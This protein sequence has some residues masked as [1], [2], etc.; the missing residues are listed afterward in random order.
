MPVQACS[1]YVAQLIIMDKCLNYALERKS[2]VYIST[3]KSYITTHI[4]CTSI[5][6]LYKLMIFSA[7]WM[8]FCWLLEGKKEKSVIFT[9]LL[10]E[11]LKKLFDDHAANTVQFYTILCVP[12]LVH[13][14]S[15][16]LSEVR[17]G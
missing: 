1:L 10:N 12:V 6:I 7:V 13:H 15:Y 4:S 9:P 14:F 3:L 17:Q 5:L 2:I 8:L 11:H 16:A